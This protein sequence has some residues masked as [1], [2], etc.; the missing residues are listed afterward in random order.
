M[1]NVEETCGRENQNLNFIL[2][3]FFILFIYLLFIYLF[4]VKLCH[5]WDIVGKFCKGIWGTHIACWICRAT[6]T[7]TRFF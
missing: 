7:H 4:F 2:N 5:L 3:N 6:D 1:R